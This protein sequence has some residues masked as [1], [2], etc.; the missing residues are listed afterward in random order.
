MSNQTLKTTL[1]CILAA[2]VFWL[3]NALNKDGYS[4]KVAYP[5]QL[6][7][8]DSLYIPTSA[9]PEKVIVNLSSTG[10][11]LLRDNFSFGVKPLV[12][13]ISNPLII[14][15]LSTISLKELLTSQMHNSKVNEVEADN[16][17]LNFE[18]KIAKKVVLKVDSLGVHLQKNYVISSPINIS[19]SMLF[20][21]GPESVLRNFQDTLL[22]RI[23][24]KTIASNFDEKVVIDLPKHPFVKASIE[25]TM[26]SFEIAEL[27]RGR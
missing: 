6:K 20:L 3:F 5:L 1:A 17:T 2:A 8:N 16:L 22:I 13:E 10:W 9:L 26:I 21:E 27:L 19:P 14:K 23:P 7:Y 11:N 15:V 12:Y 25:K 4:T 18:R 24:T